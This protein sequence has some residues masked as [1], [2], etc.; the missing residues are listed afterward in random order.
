M[1]LGRMTYIDKSSVPL[2]DEINRIDEFIPR[3]N[4]MLKSV[5]LKKFSSECFEISH[6]G[7]LRCL[8]DDVSI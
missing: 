6:N 2:E 8:K 4:K 1:K 3:P 5:Y 7:V